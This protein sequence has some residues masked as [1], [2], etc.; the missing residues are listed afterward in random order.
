MDSGFDLNVSFDEDLLSEDGLILAGDDYLIATILSSS[1][2]TV[3]DNVLSDIKTRH[4]TIESDISPNLLSINGTVFNDMN[5]NGF[6][7]EGEPGLPGWTIRLI[8]DDVGFLNATSDEFG[9]YIFEGLSPGSYIIA[10]DKTPGW[11]VTAPGGEF[12]QVTLLDM[13][14]YRY[15]FGNIDEALLTGEIPDYPAMRPSL[16]ELHRWIEAYKSAPQAA[17]D[18][19]IAAQL[20]ISPTGSLSLLNYL[21]YTPHERDQGDYCGNCWVWAGT[22]IMEIGLCVEEE[23]KNRLSI[24]YLNSNFNGGSGSNWAC[25][26]GNLDEFA[27]FYSGKG[28]A[29]PWS[30]ANAHWQDGGRTCEIGSTSVPASSITTTPSHVIT[31]IQAQ[32]VYNQGYGNAAAIANIKNVLNQNKAVAFGFLYPDDAEW[33]RFKDFWYTQPESAVYDPTFSNGKP[34]LLDN[35]YAHMILCVGYNDNDPN[36]RYWIMLNSW[37]TTAL[38]PNGLLRIEMDMNYDCYFT[39]EG[40][41]NYAFY[42]ETLDLD[43]GPNRAPTTPSTPSGSTSGTSGVSYSYTTY[44][45]DPDGDKIKYTFDWADGTT[46]ETGLLNS[47]ATASA[48]HSW[49]VPAGSTTKYNIKVKATDSRGLSTD[50]SNQLSVSIV[51]AANVPT[52]YIGVFRQSAGTFFLD[53][54]N[55]GWTSG[56]AV[57]PFGISADKPAA[58]DWD[59]DGIDEIGVF[60]PA[61]GTFFLDYQNNGWTS[62]DAV[63]P[64]GMSGD[65]PVAGDWDNDGIDEIG[66]FRPAAGTFFLDYQNNGWTSGDAVIPFGISGDLPVSGDWDNDGVD[67]IG[68]FRPSSG[69]FFLDYQNNGWTSGDAVIPFGISGD[70]PVAGDWDNDG[71]DEIGVFRPSSGTFFLDYQ[72]NGWTS[73][74]A[75]IPFGIT[76]DQPVAGCWSMTQSNS[77]TVPITVKRANSGSVIPNAL[78]TVQDG[79]GNTKQ[80][81]TNGAGQASITGISGTW[82]ISVSASGYITN[83]GTYEIPPPPAST[84]VTIYLQ[85]V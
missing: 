2:T 24:Q 69:T 51:G 37:G 58:G 54:Q 74:D 6:L 62:G 22:G 80:A 47:G 55:N 44:S 11:N 66:V 18:P 14:G 57:I 33:N 40:N 4:E 67:E 19:Q 84:S 1:N 28:K 73:G 79:A 8:R 39:Y 82:Q 76:G 7:D 63:I 5:C 48:S 77:V 49:T 27:N 15:D 12:Y 35:P 52:D 75:V 70:L 23:I 81:T 46:Y 60:R 21:Q 72:N 61:A 71:V 17:I 43:Y 25:C 29:I 78:I 31:T 32:T 34:L 38:R 9:G 50:W 3:E 42:W 16:E 56:D 13:D 59:N 30:N 45:N 41:G 26:G 68:V 85:V 36:N 64:F 10:I 20:E 53:Y 65:L 83:S